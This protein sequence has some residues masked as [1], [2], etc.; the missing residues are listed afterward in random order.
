MENVG[1]LFMLVPLQTSA[2]VGDELCH[3]GDI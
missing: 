1:T 2:D 3:S